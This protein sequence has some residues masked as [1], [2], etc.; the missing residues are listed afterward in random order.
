MFSVR[1]LLND[2]SDSLRK[3]QPAQHT[4]S[5]PNDPALLHYGN[6]GIVCLKKL[7]SLL[8]VYTKAVLCS[9]KTTISITGNTE[10]EVEKAPTETQN[11]ILND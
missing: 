8:M 9:G 5:A 2:G 10:K 11:D 3:Q 1:V 4:F 6:K 7:F